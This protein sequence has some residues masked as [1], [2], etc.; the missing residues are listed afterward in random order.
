MKVILW[1]F[2]SGLAATFAMDVV[3]AI[4]R[5]VGLTRGIDPGLLGRAVLQIF[6]RR[7]IIHSDIRRAKWS[8]S[9]LP[10]AFATHYFIGALFGIFFFLAVVPMCSQINRLFLGIA[11]GIA[12]S[13]FAW[14]AM[15]PSMGF[16]ALGLKGP[17][18]WHLLRTSL[19]N[20]FVYGLVL[21]L[22]AQ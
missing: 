14:F 4:G 1:A 12:T 19:I 15:F 8:P 2:L 20:H 7:K 6:P 5:R 18:N 10:L 11:Y 17:R 16:G 13:I 22:M 3:N 9:E 21:G